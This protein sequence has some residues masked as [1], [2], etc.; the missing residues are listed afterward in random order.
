MTLQES[1]INQLVTSRHLYYM[2]KHE[3]ESEQTIRLFSGVNLLHDS[4]EASLYAFA[5]RTGTKTR[6]DIMQTYDDIST[7]LSPKS[8]PFRSKIVELNRIRVDSKHYGI[9]PDRKVVAGLLVAMTE[10][11]KESVETVFGVN[12]LTVSLLD[13]LEDGD[14]KERLSAAQIAFDNQE[15]LSCLI[16]CRKVIYLLF[17]RYYDISSF[18]ILPS[19]GFFGA[20]S[21]AFSKSPYYAKNPQWIDENVKDP[22][23]FIQVDH[24]RLDKE[25]LK[26]G[27]AP[28]LYWNIWRGTP[29]VYKYIG[30]TNWLVKRELDVEAVATEEHA[31]YILEQTIEI[32]L[33]VEESRRRIRSVRRGSFYVHLARDRVNVYKK[34]DR[35]S[36]I[37]AITKE[38]LREI[39][40]TEETVGLNDGERYWK[41]EHGDFVEPFSMDNLYS[42]FIHNDDV[43]WSS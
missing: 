25:L 40:V 37:T 12:F 17:E 4:I 24:D 7:A 13:L 18:R 32:S 26:I 11:L 1:T 35:T 20:L 43:Y 27:I 42:G 23:E 33:Q 21:F 2:A 9:R 6:P 22:F 30:T 39:T 38:G 29:A 34:A 31:A 28:D 10:F 16:G 5:V 3:I 36:T 41:V 8:L 14:H 19:T 15:Y